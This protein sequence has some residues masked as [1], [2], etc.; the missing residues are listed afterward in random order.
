[1]SNECKHPLVTAAALVVAPDGDVLLI[2]SWKWKDRFSLPG[3]RVEW[4]ETLDEAVC[5]EVKEETNLE[6]VKLRPLSADI[7]ATIS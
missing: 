7:S 5:R 6:I 3:G 1:M 4:G 2:K